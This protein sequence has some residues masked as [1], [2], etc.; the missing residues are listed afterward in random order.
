[1]VYT[2]Y[3]L[4]RKFKFVAKAPFLK[5]RMNN[6]K[7]RNRKGIVN[8]LPQVFR[9]AGFNENCCITQKKV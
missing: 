9:L 6:S 8:F 7:S 2:I 5:V 3:K 4:I 1:M